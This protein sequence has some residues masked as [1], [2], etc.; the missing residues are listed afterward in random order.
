[1]KPIPSFAEIKSLALAAGF[2]EVFERVWPPDAL[3]PTHI[4]PFSLKALVVQGEM[5][6]TVGDQTQY[7]APA[8]TFALECNEPHAEH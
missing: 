7:L 6:L 3:V 5:W 4:H 1:M 8:N 2:D